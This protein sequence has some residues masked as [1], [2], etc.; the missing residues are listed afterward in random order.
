MRESGLDV[1]LLLIDGSTTSFKTELQTQFGG[2]IIELNL[3]R[4]NPL[5]FFKLIKIFRPYDLIHVHLFPSNYWAIVY[6]YFYAHRKVFVYT[7]HSTHS[8]KWGHPL[9]IKIDRIVYSKFDA[10]IVIS[11]GVKNVLEQVLK[12]KKDKITVIEN[13]VDLEKLKAAQALKKILFFDEDSFL[14]VKCANFKKEKDHKTLI[15]AMKKLPE[16]F[17]LLLVGDGVLLKEY[18]QLV[19]DLQLNERIKFLGTREDTESILKTSDVLVQ[20]SNYEGFGLAA[21]EAMAAGKPVVASDIPG[22]REVVEGAGL[23]FEKNNLDDLVS[24]L[25]SLY[26]DQE[27][28]NE[29]QKK[30]VERSK[31][32][33]IEAMIKA[34]TDLY[35]KSINDKK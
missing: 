7:E 35:T 22:L 3:N 11:Q 8:S 4:H 9:L 31:K 18:Q 13:G 21:V 20:S 12:L 30:C 24:K 17:K 34:L 25:Y 15:Q 27:L 29:T 28:Y 23:L 32:F 6:K 2:D 14:I 10:I 5:I 16:N 19:S 1:D 33:S 26:E